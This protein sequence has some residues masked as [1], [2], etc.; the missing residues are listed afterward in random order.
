MSDNALDFLKRWSDGPWVLTSIQ[1]DRKGIETKT[2]HDLEKVKE[3]LQRYNGHRNIY[4]HVNSV[5]HDLGKKANR[6]DIKSVDWLHVDIDPRAGE[7]LQEERER[8]LGLLTDKL[9]AGVPK[10]TCVVF[11]GGGYQGFWKLQQPIKVNGDLSNAEE[12]KRYNQQLE[13]LFGADNCHNIDRIMRLPGTINIPDARKRK[14]GRVEEEA[15]VIEFHD[16][17][18]YEL[19]S[20]S[21]APSV[22]LPED[23]G[24]GSGE[25]VTISGNIERIADLSELD[26]WSVPDRVKVIIA[27]G[28]HPEES[29][30]GDSSRSAW[31]FD[32][33]CNLVRSGVPDDTIYSIVTDPEF[34]ISESVLDKG[35]NAEK[36]AVR[37]IERAHEEAINP[38]LRYLNERFA[39]IGNMGGK[40]R[41]VEEVM[42]HSLKRTRLTRQ[43]FEDFRN[44]F[45]HRKTKIGEDKEG[46]AI[47]QPVGKWWLANEQRRQYDTIVF[48]P[49]HEVTGA[50]N[51]WKGFAYQAKPGAC[52]KFLDHTYYNICRADDKL[53]DY[54]IGWLARCVQH[55]DSPG[56][57]AVVLQGGRGTGKSF[58][59]KELGE[60]FGR[61]FLHVSNPSHLIGN[62]N[63]HLRDVVLLF[64]DEA[65]F[66]GDKKHA[67][68]LKTLITE[69]TITIEAKG[70]DAEAAP[71]Y[72]HLIMASNDRHV[73]PA[74][75]DERRFLVLQ[76]GDESKQNAKYFKAIK[77]EMENGGYEALL[78]YLLGLDL[79]DFE[80]RNVPATAALQEQKMLS[81]EIEEEWWY[82]KLIEGRLFS[83]DDD[84]SRSVRKEQLID[85][86]I[87]YAQKFGTQ[88][89]GN[90][91]IV[92][93]FLKRVCP[94]LTATQKRAKV[95]E[96]TGDG[97]VH[98]VTRRC[99]FWN[100]PSLEECRAQWDALYGAEDWEAHQMELEEPEQPK[101]AAF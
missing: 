47:L 39:V 26:E 46:N 23:G 24:F 92:G 56:E 38:W 3:W 37:Q 18:E 6:E 65:F 72:V 57:V 35:S 29:K 100:L 19:S 32:A 78:H 74:G 68:I 81:L 73:I 87:N 16:D 21:P 41:V 89:R 53:Y 11:S 45:M 4:F 66:A 55:P 22:Q 44:R 7:D 50:Y 62:F 40:C 91:T 25:T 101:K 76:V 31:L 34:P 51:M 96:P 30:E 1:P 60:L 10:P 83:D 82:N 61:H 94:G 42:D 71:N 64:A 59:A 77:Q 20:F 80:V 97:F 5:L 48:A 63:S 27:Q 12:A 14:R 93:K 2:F 15:K 99:Y 84:W 98:R 52:Q 79:S 75:G 33:I 36:Y 43:S 28:H 88:R 90:S 67:S 86:Y 58:F 17:L 9:P 54:L 70:V 85:D 95:E 8:A 49:G 69:E 13:I